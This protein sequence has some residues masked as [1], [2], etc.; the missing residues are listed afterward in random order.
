MDRCR[1]L[2]SRPPPS[3]PE[4]RARTTG[5]NATKAAAMRIPSK[6]SYLSSRTTRSLQG[7]GSVT[8]MS[9]AVPGVSLALLNNRHTGRRVLDSL[10]VKD[11]PSSRHWAAL[12]SSCY[13][14]RSDLF[15]Q[16]LADL[17]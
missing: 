9:R 1:T 4:T 16:N 5:A 8:T 11:P 14:D 10:V 15:A 3:W 17:G 2:R 7:W 13:L 12:L 6:V